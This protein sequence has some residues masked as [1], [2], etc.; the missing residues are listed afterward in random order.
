MPTLVPQCANISAITQPY[1][2]MYTH[3]YFQ[4]CDPEEGDEDYYYDEP[5]GGEPPPRAVSNGQELALTD[6][7]SPKVRPWS[8]LSSCYLGMVRVLPG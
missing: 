7:P 5:A 1:M 6:K 2:Y 4:R 8:V 3:P